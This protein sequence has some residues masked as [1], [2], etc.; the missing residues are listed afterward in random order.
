MSYSLHSLCVSM[1]V[2]LQ[3]ALF[4]HVTHDACTCPGGLCYSLVKYLWNYVFLMVDNCYIM[5]MYTGPCVC[6]SVCIVLHSDL[7]LLF[8]YPPSYALSLSLILLF[9]SHSLSLSLIPSLIHF[10][11]LFDVWSFWFIC[12]N[13]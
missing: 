9:I 6:V 10:S 13:L 3:I 2:Y 1:C 7:F 12:S 8:S 5:Y 4:G 11:Q